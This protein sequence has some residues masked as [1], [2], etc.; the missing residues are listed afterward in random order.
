[1]VYELI[2]KQECEKFKQGSSIGGADLC[3]N[4][5]KFFNCDKISIKIII[6]VKEVI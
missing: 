4:C 3:L 5:E 6:E 2:V 1:M